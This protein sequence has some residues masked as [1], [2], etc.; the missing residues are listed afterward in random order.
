MGINLSGTQ[1][2]TPGAPNSNILQA[3]FDG[4]GGIGEALAEGLNGII[5][6]LIDMVLGN[7]DGDIPAFID[8]QIAFNDRFDLLEANGYCSM[9]LGSQVR[10]PTGRNRVVPFDTRIG[11]MNHAEP[12]VVNRQHPGDTAARDEHAIRLDRKGL[13]QANVSMV[14]SQSQWASFAEIL[15]LKPDL[16]PYTAISMPSPRGED[17]GTTSGNYPSE[18]GKPISLFKMFVIPEPGYFVEVRYRCEDGGLFHPRIRG[19]S[20]FSQFAV[21]QWSSD[22]EATN[23]PENPT[24]EIIVE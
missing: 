23:A 6:G 3:I 13:W 9:T 24:S 21:T 4:I 1:P 17:D 2:S 22:V 11:P 15:V 7:Y 19:G 14:Q 20:Q 5:S 10:I 12:V 8:G 16:T 18:Q